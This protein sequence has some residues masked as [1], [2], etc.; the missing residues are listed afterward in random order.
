MQQLE[1]QFPLWTNNK[2]INKAK[3]D[4]NKNNGVC[5]ERCRRGDGLF[6]II[7]TPNKP[8]ELS[9]FGGTSSASLWQQ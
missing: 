5:A 4:N 9:P 1:D 6:G 3:S 7:K 8:M 2:N